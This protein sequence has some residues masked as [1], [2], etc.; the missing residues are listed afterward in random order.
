MNAKSHALVILLMAA[1]AV[2][3][4]QIKAFPP[5]VPVAT[6]ELA[7]SD[8]SSLTPAQII[9][10]LK[11]HIAGQQSAIDDPRTKQIQTYLESINKDITPLAVDKDTGKVLDQDLLDL[12][13]K[14]GV[15]VTGKDGKPINPSTDA[16]RADVETQQAI[17]DIAIPGTATADEK[18][19]INDLVKQARSLAPKVVDAKRAQPLLV[20]L[21]SALFRLSNTDPAVKKIVE[22]YGIKFQPGPTPEAQH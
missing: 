18:N 21:A 14:E 4:P 2:A 11:Q 19:T 9:E 8:F 7:S 5:D 12:L 16:G 15:V 1:A 10:K 13:T 3:I 6:P 17:P 22:K 20:D